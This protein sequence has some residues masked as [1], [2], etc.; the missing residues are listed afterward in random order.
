MA[1]ISN[2]TRQS[3]HKCFGQVTLIHHQ[4]DNMSLNERQSHYSLWGLL[5]TELHQHIVTLA[6]PLTVFL[7]YGIDVA[8]ESIKTDNCN[9]WH[10]DYKTSSVLATISLE[11]QH[12]SPLMLVYRSIWLDAFT[13]DWDGD[14]SLLPCYIPHIADLRQVC[15]RSM[16]MRLSHHLLS[17]T[18]LDANRTGVAGH[19]SSIFPATDCSP[20]LLRNLLIHIPMRHVWLDELDVNH[21]KLHIH[22]FVS[23]AIQFG[24]LDFLIYLVSNY[25]ITIDALC[26]RVLP[27]GLH[28]LGAV[29]FA[30]INSA[31]SPVFSQEGR[32]T[33]SSSFNDLDSDS[34]NGD[35]SWTYNVI[36]IA[37]SNNDMDMVKWLHEHGNTGCTTEAIDKASEYGYVNMVEYLH[38]HFSLLHDSLS[39]LDHVSDEDSIIRS[40]PLMGRQIGGC[41]QWAM[42]AAAQ[43]GHIDVVKFL[44]ANRTEGCTTRAM[45]EAALHGHLNII[46]F[47]HTHRTEGATSTAMDNAAAF[48][49]LNIVKWLHFN[50]T[51]GCSV[52]AMDTAAAN[53]HLDVIQFLH[54]N[55]HEGCTVKAMDAAAREG[56]LHIVKWLHENRSEGCT[57]NAMDYAACN[58]HI[59]VLVYL[60]THRSEGCTVQAINS[61]AKQGHLNIVKWLHFNRTEGCSVSAMDTAAANGHLDVIQ[62][63]HSNRHEGCTVKAMDAAAREGHLHI[64]KWLHE[65]RSEGC[66]EW[67]V[68]YAAING[69]LPIVKWLTEYRTEGFSLHALACQNTDIANHLVQSLSVKERSA[70]L[71]K[72]MERK[73]EDII[74]SRLM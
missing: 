74:I 4:Q 22:H 27:M 69:N 19:S 26:V 3:R 56:H 8:I 65:N 14:L 43:N 66:T 1:V 53:G 18:G 52:S 46:Q 31:A 29:S 32:L 11:Q 45:D 64:V 68:T 63:L 30:I 58:G 25:L 12:I 7:Y 21:L 9:L 17:I 16:Y 54:S 42:I 38:S 47:L 57:V 67:A 40:G 72:A 61:A 71:L 36:D 33:F 13:I 34:E 28:P 35:W 60:H 44:H 20:Q 51:E 49:H 2:S 6:G 55:R 62:F 10:D 5:P 41:T 39:A 37:A 48:G 59:D 15:S 23:D 50:R 24:H 70:L 73:S